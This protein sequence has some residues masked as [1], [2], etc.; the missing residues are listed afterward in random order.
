MQ[1][2]TYDS[3][4]IFRI[5]Y[6]AIARKMQPV[7]SGC[8][9]RMTGPERK[10]SR[11]ARQGSFVPLEDH[12]HIYTALINYTTSVAEQFFFEKMAVSFTEQNIQSQRCT[13]ESES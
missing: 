13:L 7:L 8:S 3:D 2:S 10:T 11:L 9:I 5:Y 12:C 1:F 6:V 4:A